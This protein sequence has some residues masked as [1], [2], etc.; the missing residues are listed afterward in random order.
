MTPPITKFLP[1]F[2]G[3]WNHFPEVLLMAAKSHWCFCWVRIYCRL[4][5]GSYQSFF[6]PTLPLCIHIT[7]QLFMVWAEDEMETLEA[8][9]GIQTGW[10]MWLRKEVDQDINVLQKLFSCLLFWW[11]IFRLVWCRMHSAIPVFSKDGRWILQSRTVA[12]KL[13][14]KK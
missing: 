2:L 14:L 12:N 8:V 5:T 4:K 9:D 10:R 1:H 11:L 3:T 6:H 13:N 7:R